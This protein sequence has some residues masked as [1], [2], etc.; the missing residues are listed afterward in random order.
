LS[1]CIA[2]SLPLGTLSAYATADGSFSLYS[3]HFN[4]AFHSSAGALTEAHAKFVDPAQLERFSGSKQLRVLDVCVG[5]GYNSAALID[6]LQGNSISLQWWGLEL[7]PRPLTMAL[8]Q[9]S[10]KV[11]WSPQVLTILERIR[12]CNSW[13]EGSS[14]GTL[15]WGDARQK[16]NWL[17]NDLKIDLILLDAF[18][19]S[20]C[21]Q[22]WSDEFLTALV[23]R[24][25]PGGRLLTYCRAAAVRATLRRAGMQLCSLLTVPGE[26]QGWSDGTLAILPDPDEAQSLQGPGWQPLTLME[27]EHLLTRAA[28]PYRDPSGQATVEEIIKRRREEQ[29]ECKMESTNAWKRRWCRN[30]TGECQ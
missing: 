16:L 10:F 2:E 24:L 29:R 22:L 12:D 6:A 15:F 5:L 9:S 1:G 7:D 11:N 8:Q 27:E 19:P 14:N 25:A 4:E 3:S 18:S 30:R 28:I 17:P 26:R 21:P 13:R 20:R 23:R